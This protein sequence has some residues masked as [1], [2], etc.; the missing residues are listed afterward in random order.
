M[1]PDE[2]ESPTAATKFHLDFDVSD[3]QA[4]TSISN[5]VFRSNKNISLYLIGFNSTLYSTQ[6][7]L[8]LDWTTPRDWILGIGAGY[9][10][11][12][13]QS[14]PNVFST[15]PNLSF[16]KKFT[17]RAQNS[18]P[19]VFQPSVKT[20][21]KLTYN[22]LEQKSFSANVGIFDRKTG[23]TISVVPTTI[24]DQNLVVWDYEAAV[25]LDLKEWFRTSIDYQIFDYQADP[26][27]FSFFKT[28]LEGSPTSLNAQEL[29]GSIDLD[30][31]WDL[32]LEMKVINSVAATV[33]ATTTNE[34]TGKLTWSLDSMAWIL[35]YDHLVPISATSPTDSL[36]VGFRAN[37]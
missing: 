27:S 6:Y 2:K 12:T 20:Q 15:T 9:M 28:P 30:F 21:L 4:P 8:S 24:G 36:I 11:Q 3:S 37:L 7:D 19:E 10:R 14:L 32:S 18:D 31:P 34:Y 26:N 29:S 22:T 23:T 13:A 16:G 35:G 25:D 1:D 5:L 33:D 17:S